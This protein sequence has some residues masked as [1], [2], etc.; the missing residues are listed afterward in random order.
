[1]PIQ[2]YEE[3]SKKLLAVHVSG[4]LTAA[5]CGHFVPEFE[6]LTGLHGKLHVLFDVIFPCAL[7]AGIQGSIAAHPWLRDFTLSTLRPPWLLGR[8]TGGNRAFRLITH[9]L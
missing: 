5:D 7:V 2:L 8:G 4:K 3:N 1:M 9:R 6:R